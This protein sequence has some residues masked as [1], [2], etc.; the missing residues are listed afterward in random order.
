MLTTKS[1]DKANEAQAV[2][3]MQQATREDHPHH[4]DAN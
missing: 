3:G 2:H 1:L 4:D